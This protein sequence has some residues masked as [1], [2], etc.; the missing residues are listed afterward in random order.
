MHKSYSIDTTAI[1]HIFYSY[2]NCYTF[3]KRVFQ[4]NEDKEYWTYHHIINGEFGWVKMNCWKMD[5]VLR[6]VFQD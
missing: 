4:L 6:R 3:P 5:Y 1:E 2:L